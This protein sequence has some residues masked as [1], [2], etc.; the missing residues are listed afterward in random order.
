MR[1]E[2]L[3][4]TFF[5]QKIYRRDGRLN[6]APP[7]ALEYYVFVRDTW[8]HSHPET[9]EI[10][11]VALRPVFTPKEGYEVVTQIFIPPLSNKT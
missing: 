6:P 2:V 1:V 11:G 8:L 9:S 3:N 10:P 7:E 5:P 4:Q